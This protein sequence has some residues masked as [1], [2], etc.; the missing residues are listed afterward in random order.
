MMTP[1]QY[2]REF[3]KMT[4]EAKAL[5][6]TRPMFFGAVTFFVLELVITFLLNTEA[7]RMLLPGHLS[8]SLYR[9][10]AESLPSWPMRHAHLRVFSGV[11]N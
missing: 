5:S 11:R 10:S 4:E 2:R 1:A 7:G 9:I 3:P 6:F 8:L